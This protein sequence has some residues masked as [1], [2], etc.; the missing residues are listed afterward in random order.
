MGEAEGEIP[1]YKGQNGSSPRR[2]L[3]VTSQREEKGP[4]R[5]HHF[6]GDICISLKARSQGLVAK[7]P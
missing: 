3:D 2:S 5:R 7:G 4:K 1:G 6:M